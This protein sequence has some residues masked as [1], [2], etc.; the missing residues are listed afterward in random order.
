MLGSRLAARDRAA[1]VAFDANRGLPLARRAYRS[2]L[3]PL[4]CLRLSVRMRGHVGAAA[5]DQKV[6]IASLVGLQYVFYVEM[7]VAAGIAG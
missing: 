7:A 5:A 6:E 4:V 1:N 2:R 3:P